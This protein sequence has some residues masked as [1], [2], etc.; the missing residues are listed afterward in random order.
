MKRK[1]MTSGK[2]WQNKQK[3]RGDGA[4]EPLKKEEKDDETMRKEVQ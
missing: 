4:E 3:K 2:K 1:K